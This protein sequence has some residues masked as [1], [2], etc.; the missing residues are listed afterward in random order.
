M[1][2][3]DTQASAPS[4]PSGFREDSLDRLEFSRFKD[5]LIA[6]ATSHDG[7]GRIR[8]L[9]PFT[10][11]DAARETL[12]R[13]AELKARTEAG[14]GLPPLEVGDLGP[15]FGRL[16][17]AGSVLAPEEFLALSPLLNAA[18]G[19]KARL[20]AARI[21]YPLLAGL[22]EPLTPLPHLERA[23]AETFDPSGEIRDS[24]SPEL[25]RLR[26]EREARRER[27]RARM[28]RLAARLAEHDS[29]S[30]VTL[31]EDR[32][33]LAVPQNQRSKVPGLV[34]DRSASGATFYVEPMEVVEDNN[35]LRELEAEERAEV[36]RILAG[37]TDRFRSHAGE[38]KRNAE[39]VGRLDALRARALLA[40]R[41]GAEAP[42]LSEGP[43]L[44]LTGARH[45]LLLEARRA[46][47][48][49]EAARDSVIPLELE[50]DARTRVL[51]ITGPNMGGKTVALKAVGLLSVM[52]QCGCLIPADPGCVLPWTTRWVVS[53]GD[54]Q[55]LE[56]DLSTFAAHLARWGEA[57][58]AAGA[59]AL[60]LLDELGSGTDPTEGAALAR[61]VL[62][63][64]VEAGS[65]GLVTTHLGVLK[66]F[67]AEAEGIQN[68]SMVFDPATRRPTYRLAVGVPGESHAIDMARRLGFPEERVARAEALLPREERDVKRLLADLAEERTRLG[69][70]RREVEELRADAERI[71]AERRERL[72]RVIEERATVRARAARQAREILRRAEETLRAAE[73]QA[74][75]QAQSGRVS[76]REVAREQSRLARL[77]A[78]A[79]P[80]RVRGRVPDRIEAGGRYWSEVLGREVEVVREADASG[81]VLVLQGTVKVELPA[82]SLRTTEGAPPPAAGPGAPAGR[83]PA[84]A[85]PEVEAPATEVDLRGMRVEEALEKLDQA[86]DRALLAGLKEVRVIHGKGT[87]AL[88][89]AVREFGRTHGAVASSRMADQWEGGTGATVITLEG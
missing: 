2:V 9:V 64:L 15:V 4:P 78:P 13:V 51:L 6:L 44:R 7:A 14:D 1:T 26:R 71:A 50:L 27:L 68:A 22:G 45:P 8:A 34:Q 17:M 24:A 66:G 88:R 20:E 5:L 47:G 49:T 38:L 60:I 61:S 69:A 58:E 79:R 29:G 73:S 74:R 41:W 37:L 32:Y 87:G 75:T 25:R 52:A 53:L 23:L 36:R 40:V 57:L 83:P 84:A 81:R 63:R 82:S 3:P 12:A 89:A 70:A 80:R 30:L 18:R 42:V 46:A 55:S 10:E 54:E 21:E 85:I 28:E 56:A 31:R 48:G 33:V 77:E 16:A 19:A 11:V 43:E 76:R 59:G 67:A 72:A 39:H 62:E 65:L 86:L 35:S